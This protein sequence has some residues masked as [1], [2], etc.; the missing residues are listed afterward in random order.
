MIM[1]G[2]CLWT[3]NHYTQ[4]TIMNGEL[5]WMADVYGGECCGFVGGGC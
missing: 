3:A 4:R 2:K 1:D 5:L